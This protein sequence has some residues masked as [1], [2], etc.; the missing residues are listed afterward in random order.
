MTDS[1]S[2]TSAT[3]IERSENKLTNILTKCEV[4]LA[5]QSWIDHS[6]DLFKDSQGRPPCVG[7]PDSALRSIIVQ[8]FTSTIAISRPASVPAGSNWDCHIVNKQCNNSIILAANSQ[9]H[10][11]L[12]V[13]D[14][15][16]ATFNYG[17]VMI[18]SG[19][20]GAALGAVDIVGSL[21]VPATFFANENSSRVI[22]KAHEIANTTA[23]LNKQGS[24]LCYQKPMVDP[25]VTQTSIM[26]VASSDAIAQGSLTTVLD[27]DGL[28]SPAQLLNYPKSK[29]WEAKDG[30]YQT[31]VFCSPNNP[32]GT[33][34]QISVMWHDGKRAIA[35]PLCSQIVITPY[36]AALHPVSID[37]ANFPFMTPFNE[38]GSYFTGLSSETTLQLTASW[39]IETTP[40]RNDLQLITLCRDSPPLDNCALEQ[41]SQIAHRLPAGVPV[42][43]NAAG[44]WINLIADVAAAAGIPGAGLIK[45]GGGL[46]NQAIKFY[47]TDFG[48][49]TTPDQSSKNNKPQMK[50]GRKVNQK[51][52][53]DWPKQPV[54][55]IVIN[56]IKPKIKKKKNGKLAKS[57]KPG[58]RRVRLI[59]V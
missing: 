19:P 56:D 31:S 9:L 55:R 23:T 38:S 52:Y 40:S 4:T 11:N 3:K 10:Y 5:G 1:N 43:D 28:G 57:T 49:M 45:M 21:S 22:G 54:K 47:K 35:A 41:Y 17:G 33:D 48:R 36:T 14:N 12:N 29:I 20:A 2:S 39:M 34:R 32:P 59:T 50:I 6:L 53:A 18:F 25:Y 58:Q 42:K 27:I 24:V 26:Q 37:L 46:V 44:D 16:H 30:T 15:P 8:K 7:M 13:R 51:T